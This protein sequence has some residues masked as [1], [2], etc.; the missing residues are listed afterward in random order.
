MMRHLA[1]LVTAGALLFA[2]FNSWKPAEITSP[3]AWSDDDEAFALVILRYEHRASYHPLDGTGKKRNVRHQVYVEAANGSG[4]VAVGPEIPGQNGAE[5][6]FMRSMGYLVLSAEDEHHRWY[7]RIAL[8][9]TRSEIARLDKASCEARYFDVV[10]SPDGAHLARLQTAP[11]C[12]PSGTGPTSPTGSS[13]STQQVLV[14][15]LDAITL[16]EVASHTLTLNNWNLDW[17]WT[18][19]GDFI[20]HD[21]SSG[22]SLAPGR[23]PVGSAVPG[24]S[25]PK[26]TSSDWSAG[27]TFIYGED[28]AVLVGGTNPDGAFGCQ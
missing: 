22:W 23:A 15:F 24:C 12:P 16:Q 21:Q 8:D 20:V 7:T 18:P 14:T 25:W 11:G 4:R 17:T 3:V 13:G 26:T 19:D 27:G 5:L 2:C 6:Y 28:G 1:I 9:G 10:P